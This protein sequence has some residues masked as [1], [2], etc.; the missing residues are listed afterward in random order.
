MRLG[1][2]AAGVIVAAVFVVAYS[3]RPPAGELRPQAG[4]KIP[5]PLVPKPS[6]FEIPKPPEHPR[7]PLRAPVLRS[8]IAPPA[9]APSRG[10]K[11]RLAFLW[12]FRRHSQSR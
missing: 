6:P 11:H 1:G 5:G 7:L 3:W 4:L 10:F 12:P 8:S 2:T 9:R